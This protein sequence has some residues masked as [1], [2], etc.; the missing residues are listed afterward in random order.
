M[1]EDR[2]DREMSELRSSIEK[3]ELSRTEAERTAEGAAQD[4]E[5]GEK[6]CAM[7]GARTLILLARNGYEWPALVFENV[8]TH[9]LLIARRERNVKVPDSSVIR[10]S[11]AAYRAL[12]RSNLDEVS[13]G[14]TLRPLRHAATLSVRAARE[15]F[16]WRDIR[17]PDLVH[18]IDNAGETAV[19]DALEEHPRVLGSDRLTSALVIKLIRKGQSERVAEV[20]ERRDPRGRADVALAT[21]RYK[22]SQFPRLMEAR[23]DL[24]DAAT[25]AEISTMLAHPN[26]DVRRAVIRAIGASRERG[27]RAAGRARSR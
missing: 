14:P 23:P 9:A 13:E 10:A 26:L 15:L 18:V 7:R 8:R 21:C 27:E 3:R 6:D 1:G 16:D 24:L 4:V 12:V 5:S 11:V 19:L 22:F 25:E 17:D 2:D 20:L